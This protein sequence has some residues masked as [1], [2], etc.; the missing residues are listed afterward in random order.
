MKISFKLLESDKTISN[1]ILKALLSDIKTFVNNS[2]NKIK[3]ELPLIVLN[4]IKLSP[5][6]SE[7]IS[8]NLRLE[9]GI[10]DPNTKVAGLIEIWSKNIVYNYNKPEI[11]N[12]KIKSSFSVE[13][14]KSDF[15]DV[16]G[17]DYSI[18][19]DSVR[20]YSLPWL[21]WLLLD[22]SKSI[23][24]NYEVVFGPNPASRTGSAIMYPSSSSWGISNSYAG[25]ISDNWIT[26]SIDS[27]EGQISNLLD[28]AFS[29]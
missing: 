6:Y 14:I 9:L 27:A 5:E 22:G 3:Q 24:K 18:V 15:S 13:M 12:N 4:S 7:L 23:V 26:R 19:V 21:E 1:K 16:L 29:T 8:G 25:T 2:F 28:K 20:G 11:K 17:S 10:A